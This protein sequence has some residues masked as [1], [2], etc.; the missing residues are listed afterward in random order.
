MIAE[1]IMEIH[2]MRGSLHSRY[3]SSQP[4]ITS[5]P[6]PDASSPGSKK[7]L[8]GGTADIPSSGLLPEQSQEDPCYPYSDSSSILS[9]NPHIGID[10]MTTVKAQTVPV[11]IKQQ[12]LS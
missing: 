6:P 12:W 8:N 5:T 2:R 9:E 11:M 7:I 3:G 4:N 10:M 1:E